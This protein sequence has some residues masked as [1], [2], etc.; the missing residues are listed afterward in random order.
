M[1]D[2]RQ[3]KR[4]CGEETQK[5]WEIESFQSQTDKN[6]GTIASVFSFND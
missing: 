4:L 3:Q 6:Y 1:S 5:I 2:P